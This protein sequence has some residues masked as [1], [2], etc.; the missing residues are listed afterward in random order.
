MKKI[1]SPVKK[2]YALKTLVFTALSLFICISQ[3]AYAQCCAKLTSTK[4]CQGKNT[5]TAT[6]TPCT[7]GNYTY[8][9]DDASMQ[10]TAVATSLT[11]GIYHVVISSGNVTCPPL[12]VT[13]TDSSCTPFSVPNIMTPNGDGINDY[14][15][16]TG[17]QKGTKLTVFNRW[18][19]IVYSSNNYDNDWTASN[20]TDGVYF[21]TLGLPS[22]ETITGKNDPS[23]GFVQIISGN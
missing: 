22:S 1:L 11:V 2:A 7:P 17:L 20:L 3:T 9:W 12:E 21:Y 4:T 6:I 14:F 16:I 19:A 15:V 23:R 8:M 5:G 13:V 10:T 18:G